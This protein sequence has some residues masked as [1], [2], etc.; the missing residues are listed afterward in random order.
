MLKGSAAIA[1]AGTIGTAAAVAGSA[2]AVVTPD[3]ELVALGSLYA[4]VNAE[5]RRLQGKRHRGTTCEGRNH[6]RRAGPPRNRVAGR[7]LAFGLGGVACAR[8]SPRC[9]EGVNHG[10]DTPANPRPAAAID[11]LKALAAE[12]GDHLLLAYG[13][14]NPDAALMYWICVST[15]RVSERLWTQ[16]RPGFGRGFCLTARLQNPCLRRE[17]DHMRETVPCC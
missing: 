6:C 13:P 4:T 9:G 15:S 8:R 12:A 10:H 5:I 3:A 7:R 16:P 11:R 14:A 1:A 17:L 2:S